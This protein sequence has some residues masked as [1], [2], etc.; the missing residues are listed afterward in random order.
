MQFT[1]TGRRWQQEQEPIAHI[2]WLVRKQSAR[3]K[4]HRAYL[5]SIGP[6]SPTPVQV[7]PLARPQVLKAYKLLRQ[8][9]QL[10]TT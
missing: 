8:Y 2:T 5:K 1:T 7:L 4:N 6:P 9:R 3:A 10:G